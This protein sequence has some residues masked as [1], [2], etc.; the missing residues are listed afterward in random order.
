MRDVD[1]IRSLIF[2]FLNCS[3]RNDVE[4]TRIRV[5]RQRLESLSG[6]DF[7]PSVENWLTWYESLG[8]ELGEDLKLAKK[9]YETRVRL[10]GMPPRDDNNSQN[11][12]A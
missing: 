1:E 9:M 10:R 3:A 8:E 5:I 12:Q 11:R 4:K 2:H 6:E 7:G